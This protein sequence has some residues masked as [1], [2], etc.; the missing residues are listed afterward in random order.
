MRNFKIFLW[1]FIIFLIQ[2]VVLARV[3]ILGAVP[4][5][6]TAYIVC[7][8]LLENEFRNAFIISLICAASAGA[9]CGREFVIT[10]LF[11][12][13]SSI[14]IFVLRKK[15]LYIGNMPKALFW[16]FISS[17]AMEVVFFAAEHMT[18]NMQMLIYNAI[19]T[20]IFNMALAAVVY[21]LLNAIMY[22]EKKKKLL[23]V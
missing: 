2:T 1:I 7:V 20:A 3:H 4:S 23:I 14:M 12:L 5:L 9:L 22:K 18:V 17:A 15:P 6:V 19:P 16:T 21:P 13:Y 10:V 8:M 11:Y